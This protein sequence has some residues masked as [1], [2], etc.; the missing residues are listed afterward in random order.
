M[1]PK[2][3]QVQIPGNCECHLDGK[4]DFEGVIKALKVG[5]VFWIP[6]IGPK[7]NH[8]G[9]YER[10]TGGIRIRDINVVTESRD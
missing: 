10:D 6:L 2:D 7:C 3:V 1:T 9:P 5:K 8:K 4:R